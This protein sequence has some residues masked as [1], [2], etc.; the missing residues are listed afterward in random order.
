[1]VLKIGYLKVCFLIIEIIRNNYKLNNLFNIMKIKT[2]IFSFVF[3][4][5]AALF[6]SLFTSTGDWYESVKPSIT[7]P[8]FVFP[9][10]WTILF[11]LISLSLYFAL[12][13]RKKV[14][15]IFG[16]NLIFNALWSYFFF[17][18]HKP[19]LAFIDLILIWITIFI[20]IYSVR[21]VKISAY[22]LVPYLIWV[23][24]AGI[25]NYLIA[26]A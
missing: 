4:H 12:L 21:K 25:L 19:L 8:S 6:G 14:I 1:M 26:F 13:K 22:M 3:V 2:L 9:I 5:L 7:P 20:M 24:F 23:S 17:G 15:L 16:I 10:V 11:I 18:L